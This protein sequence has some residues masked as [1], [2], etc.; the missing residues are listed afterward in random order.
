MQSIAILQFYGV[1]LHFD[2]LT[3]AV[4]LRTNFMAECERMLRRAV[5][6]KD[7]G[8]AHPLL[9]LLLNVA[10][11]PAGARNLVA[12]CTDAASHQPALTTGA[13]L[14][15]RNFRRRLEVLF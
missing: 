14:A 15:E 6:S 5:Q 11:L 8:R 13:C 10:A 1:V 3:Q 2:G 7:S 9:L 4:L 12:R